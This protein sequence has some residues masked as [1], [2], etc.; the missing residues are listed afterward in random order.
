MKT[1][2]GLLALVMLFTSAAGAQ[3]SISAVRFEQRIGAQLPRTAVFLDVS[4]RLAT[5]G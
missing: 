3:P 5:M 2:V 1:A 4:G